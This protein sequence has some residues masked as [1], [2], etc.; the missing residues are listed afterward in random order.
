MIIN[1]IRTAN[2][3]KANNMVEDN[4]YRNTII[5][6]LRSFSRSLQ[7]VCGEMVTVESNNNDS[8]L[9]E[10]KRLI[11]SGNWE[12]LALLVQQHPELKNNLSNYARE[13]ENRKAIRVI[14]TGVSKLKL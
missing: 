2:G 1:G 5:N 9:V 12:A 8:L 7:L 3:E 14:F 10:G 6:L 13:T 11:E 4:A